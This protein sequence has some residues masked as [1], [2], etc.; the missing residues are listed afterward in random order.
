MKGATAEPLA[1]TIKPPNITIIKRMGIS[2]NF[3]RTLM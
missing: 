2:Q 3:F 1:S